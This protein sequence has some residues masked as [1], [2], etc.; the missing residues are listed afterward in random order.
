M[1]GGVCLGVCRHIA[2]S[3]AGIHIDCSC[4]GTH[5]LAHG[6]ELDGSWALLNHQVG[7]RRHPLLGTQ[8][9]D[10]GRAPNIAQAC[11]QTGTHTSWVKSTGVHNPVCSSSFSLGPSMVAHRQAARTASQQHLA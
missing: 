3:T 11:V 4:A 9:H 8:Q 10:D 5:G 6:C 2:V 1:D 7:Q